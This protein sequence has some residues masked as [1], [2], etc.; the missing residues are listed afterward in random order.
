MR[1]GYE[2][3][4]L[5]NVTKPSDLR[6]PDNC[7]LIPMDGKERFY[8]RIFGLPDSIKQQQARKVFSILKKLSFS[9]V[10]DIGCAQGQYSIR[11]ARRYPNLRI[12]GVDLDEKKIFQ[13]ACAKKKFGLRNLIFVKDDLSVNTVTEKHD[14]VLL[15]QVIEHLRDDRAMLARI[16]ELMSDNG[17]LIITGPNVRSPIINWSKKYVD[18]KGHFRDGYTIE[19]LS[20][21]VVE[22]NFKIKEVRYLSGTI[23][24]SIEKV[25][26]ILKTNFPSLVFAILYPLLNAAAYID[27]YLKP[28]DNEHASGILIVAESR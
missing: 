25:E 24:Q 17:H 14:L 10:L 1:L 6:N 27:D 22:A 11:I 18:I 7:Q 15:L 20:K 19:H 21:I 3:G 28:K 12:K 8:I 4:Y 5:D 13:A 26:T 9:S 23:G 2:L 16:R